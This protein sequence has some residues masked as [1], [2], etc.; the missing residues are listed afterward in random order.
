MIQEKIFMISPG[1]M[2]QGARAWAW[3]FL[4]T[5]P[6]LCRDIT[7]CRHPVPSPF[8][9]ALKKNNRFG[10]SPKVPKAKFHGCDRCFSFVTSNCLSFIIWF[11]FSCFSW[12]FLATIL[13]LSEHFRRS[14]SFLS[15]QTKNIGWCTIPP[16]VI[17]IAKNCFLLINHM[18]TPSVPQVIPDLHHKSNFFSSHAIVYVVEWLS[19]ATGVNFTLKVCLSSVTHLLNTFC[20]NYIKGTDLT[21]SIGKFHPTNIFKSRAN[22]LHLLDKLFQFTVTMKKIVMARLVK[23][24]MR[25]RFTK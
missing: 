14:R 17:F 4:N 8:W 22:Q 9:M 19:E 12:F 16:F 10:H 2:E 11:S 18:I 5:I 7:F 24:V 23:N 25:V 3:S 1:P 15:V 13:S 20:K 6:V 21:L